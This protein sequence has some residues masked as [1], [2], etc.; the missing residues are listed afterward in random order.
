[1]TTAHTKLRAATAAEKAADEALIA[2]RK[3]VKSARAE[4]SK[5][6]VEAKRE[7]KAAQI[8]INTVRVERW[9]T[10]ERSC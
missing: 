3:A 9:Q 5:L 8:K 6:E 2:S 1:M 4:I 10:R 7:A